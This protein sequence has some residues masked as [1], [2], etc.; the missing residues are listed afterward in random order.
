MDVV[1]V[2]DLG[3]GRGGRTP[4]PPL[5]EFETSVMGLFVSVH[6]HPPPILTPRSVFTRVIYLFKVTVI[7]PLSL[8]SIKGDYIGSFVCVLS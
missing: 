1:A 2:A 8:S 3:G 4:P 5:S 6:P 7:I